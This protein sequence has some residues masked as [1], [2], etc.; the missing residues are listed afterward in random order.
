[1]PGFLDALMSERAMCSGANIGV[2]AKINDI[3]ISR[4]FFNY[5]RRYVGYIAKWPCW[6]A[7]YV[8][9]KE[10]ITLVL[11][12]Q[13]PVNSYIIVYSLSL[14]TFFPRHNSN[15]LSGMICST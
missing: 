14:L 13:N 2:L 9:Q 1:M 6:G 3:V 10:F 11:D 7:I 4:G 8:F 5:Y 12:I 15:L